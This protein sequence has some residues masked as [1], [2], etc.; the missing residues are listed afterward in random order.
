MPSPR[1]SLRLLRRLLE[2]HVTPYDHMLYFDVIDGRHFVCVWYFTPGPADGYV[3]IL[4]SGWTVVE[5]LD[6]AVANAW[7]EGAPRPPQ[8]VAHPVGE[9]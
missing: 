2:Q 6:R 3:A 1:A 4:G 7:H 8:L 5:A 9:A